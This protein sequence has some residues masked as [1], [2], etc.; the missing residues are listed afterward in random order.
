MKPVKIREINF[1][2][3]P[4]VLSFYELFKIRMPPEIPELCNTMQKLTLSL[5]FW[6]NLQEEPKI[7]TNS[8]K[9]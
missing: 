5:K 3:N 7:H 4:M 8:H 6:Q 2:R 1:K 9:F